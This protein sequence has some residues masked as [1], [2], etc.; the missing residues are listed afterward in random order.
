MPRNPLEI[1][2]S[3][4]SC[5]D[6]QVNPEELGPD[7]AFCAQSGQ[8]PEPDLRRNEFLCF[9]ESTGD[10]RS[11]EP[12]QFQSRWRRGPAGLIGRERRPTSDRRDVEARRRRASSGFR[13]FRLELPSSRRRSTGR[14]DRH[15]H[16]TLSEKN[17][18]GIKAMGVGPLIEGMAPC[19]FGKAWPGNGRGSQHARVSMLGAAIGEEASAQ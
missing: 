13:S 16:V 3:L 14:G 17:R 18:V 5:L 10:R 15:R 2:Q 7:A 1:Q 19:R 12:F 11:H 9:S 6:P 8:S 4:G